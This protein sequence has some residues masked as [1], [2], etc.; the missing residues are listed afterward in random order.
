MGMRIQHCITHILSNLN[1][2]KM[3]ITSL[4]LVIMLLPGVAY[5]YNHF[6]VA[7]KMM[8]LNNAHQFRRARNLNTELIDLLSYNDMQLHDSLFDGDTYDTTLANLQ[9]LHDNVYTDDTYNQ[10][11]GRQKVKRRHIDLLQASIAQQMQKQQHIKAS[12]NGIMLRYKL[13]MAAA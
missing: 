12:I 7:P 8:A 13:T 5:A 11:V 2:K 3:L 9:L 10:L 6:V 4:Y 1:L